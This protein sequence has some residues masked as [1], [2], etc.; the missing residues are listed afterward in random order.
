MDR[1][2]SVCLIA[3]G[4]VGAMWVGLSAAASIISVDNE[5]GLDA[6]T[7][8]TD[9]SLEFLDLTLTTQISYHEMQDLINPGGAYEGW[10]HASSGE[11]LRMVINAGVE[12]PDESGKYYPPR[13]PVLELIDL[14]GMNYTLAPIIPE[15]YGTLGFT[16]ETISD[17]EQSM[18]AVF[19]WF[20][21]GFVSSEGYRS[22]SVQHFDAGHWLV[23]ENT[24]PNPGSL[25]LLSIAGVLATRR[26]RG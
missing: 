6:G 16:R 22:P 23:R 19:S 7:V 12:I 4:V 18:F 5:F 21:T 10:R 25:S 8:D 20:T 3:F 24:I 15:I 2:I 26:R 11:V 14:I 13:G 17:E 9:Q 1:D